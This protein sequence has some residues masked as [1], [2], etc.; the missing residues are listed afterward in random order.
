MDNK[1]DFDHLV[2]SQPQITLS[3]YEYRVSRLPVRRHPRR[4]KRQHQAP[5]PEHSDEVTPSAAFPSPNPATSSGDSNQAALELSNI[6]PA[7]Q[8]KNEPFEHNDHLPTQN[9][10]SAHMQNECHSLPSADTILEYDSNSNLDNT[11]TA[12]TAHM[13]LDDDGDQA[14][15]RDAND[16]DS[17]VPTTNPDDEDDEQ[18]SN[19]VSPISTQDD[20]SARIR[21]ERKVLNDVDINST[22]SPLRKKSSRP[23]KRSKLSS[24]FEAVL[25]SNQLIMV[26]NGSVESGSFHVPYFHTFCSITLTLTR[27]LHT[28]RPTR[29]RSKTHKCTSDTIHE[30]HRGQQG[31]LRRQ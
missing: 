8:S 1:Q 20:R 18:D 14:L 29:M 27:K 24:A 22:E 3:Q 16:C 6:T 28:L 5:T 11:F 26:S 17:D 23:R 25:A 21:S 30:N 13:Y 12:P 4:R 19:Y 7:R 15:L 9:T 2:S 31:L 10:V